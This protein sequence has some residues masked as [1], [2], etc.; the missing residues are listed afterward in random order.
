MEELDEMAMEL[1]PPDEDTAEDDGV[2]EEF[3]EEELLSED[4]LLSDDVFWLEED[5]C[6]AE[7]LLASEPDDVSCTPVAFSQAE[8]Q[9]KLQALKSSLSPILKTFPFI[10]IPSIMI[11]SNLSASEL[12]ICLK[13]LRINDRQEKS[14]KS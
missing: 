7:E 6:S 3:P 2:A 10:M 14:E 12:N 9:K 13:R 8:T 5:A 11:P 4:A 1:T